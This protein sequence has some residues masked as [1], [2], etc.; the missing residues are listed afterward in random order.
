MAV[1]NYATA[2]ANVCGIK[3][4]TKLFAFAT[5]FAVI[6]IRYAYR[7]LAKYPDKVQSSKA[8]SAPSICPSILKNAFFVD[9]LMVKYSHGKQS[10]L[11]DSIRIQWS[12]H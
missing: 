7:R 5:K 1:K 2:G 9:T 6:S 12:A 3:D 8:I 10:L 11:G 4:A